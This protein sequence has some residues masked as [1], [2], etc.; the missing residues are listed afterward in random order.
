MASQSELGHAKNVAN[1][2]ELITF[3]KSLG[4]QYK[5]MADVLKITA[6][7]DLDTKADQALNDLKQAE[8]LAKQATANLQKHFKTLNTLSS[9]IMGLLKSSGTKKSSIEEANIIHKLITGANSKKKKTETDTANPSEAKSTRSQSR[10]SYDSRL[11]N[12]EKL[13]MILQNIP[14]YKPN[15]EG[16]KITDLQSKAQTMKQSIQDDDAKE[17]NRSRLMTERNKVLY[18]PDTGLVDIGLMAKE[19]IKGAFGGVKSAE[20]K[21]ISKIKF[22]N[23]PK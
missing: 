17:L 19:Y 16:F 15:E 5:P 18:T 8:T 9:Q 10:Q 2:K 12:F 3:V 21:I 14:E 20:Y 4:T 11:D 23:K 7:Q 13:I 22:S 1:F 6:L